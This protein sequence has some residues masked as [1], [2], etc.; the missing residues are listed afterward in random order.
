MLHSTNL[1]NN[2]DEKSR[3]QIK[4][5]VTMEMTGVWNLGPGNSVW[6]KILKD[7]MGL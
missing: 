7:T 3:P 4:V 5:T 1:Q 6:K 2:K